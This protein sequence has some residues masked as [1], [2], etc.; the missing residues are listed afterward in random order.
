MKKT[1]IFIQVTMLSVTMSL[2]QNGAISGLVTDTENEPIPGALVR[3]NPSSLGSV[4]DSDGEYII[5]KI[6]AGKYTLEASYLGFEL[7][8][9]EVTVGSEEQIVVN[10][11]MEESA[12]ALQEVEVIGRTQTEYTPDVTFSATRTG[13]TIKEVPQSIAVLNKEILMDQ[14]I[15]RVAE[16]SENV[17]GITQFR[18]DQFT[19]RGF[20]IKQ[21]Y[22]NGNRVVVST[23]FSATSFTSHYER[24]E[25]VKGPAAALFG[26]SSPGGIVNAVTK[27]PLKNRRASASFTFGSFDT[28]R[29]TTDITGP[30]NEEKNLLYRVNVA[31]ENAETFRDF[32][33]NR[34]L[35]IAPSISY[36]PDNKTS[37]NVDLVSTQANDQAGVDRGMPVLQGDLFALP[38]N[39]NTAEP[40]DN[41]QNTN[42]LLTV[43]ANRK[44]TDF[45]SFNAS[46]SRSDFDQ[47]FLETRSSNQFTDDG[48]ELIRAVNDRVTTAS[49]NFLA[50][51]LVGKF[52]TGSFLKHELVLGFDYFENDQ[53]GVTRSA[54][55]EVNGV[56]NLVFSD[57]EVFESL[58]ELLL[59]LS[60]AALAFDLE[61][62]YRG[63]YIQDLIRIGGRLNILAGLRYEDL[64]QAGLEG[65]GVDL[66]DAIDNTVLLPRFGLTYKLT[67]QINLFASY[68]ESFNLQNFPTGVNSLN[69]GEAFDPLES[70]QIEFGTKTSFFNNRLL[71]QVS[72]YAINQSG[73]LIE[74]PSNT[75]G[76]IRLIQLGEEESQGV[77]LDITGS[78]LPNLSIT[79]NYAY[80]DVEITEVEDEISVLELEN[81]NP[82]HTAGFW[83]KYTL[84][85]GLLQNLGIG[86]GLRYVSD[87]QTIDPAANLIDNVI[88]F[89][90]YFTAKGAIYYQYQNMKL[91]FNVNNIFD[92]RYFIGGLN[93]G[94]VFPGAPRNYL[95]TVSYTF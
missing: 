29:A 40:Y 23:D 52:K 32:Q 46:F 13:A 21:D 69:P 26:N 31:W 8:I 6:K 18:P 86:L 94:R 78:I 85:G 39:F 36:F 45:L 34:G 64:D 66:S 95:A 59:N 22:I 1:I 3:L 74:D 16:I 82:Q 44:V 55:G 49:S 47:N 38:I 50:T 75:G 37:I 79:A 84:T 57:R 20:S 51:Y 73:R 15:F 43:S 4:S 61:N 70:D 5:D 11:E 42:T 41:R 62:S 91:S 60:E 90:S 24:V 28:F 12:Y 7:F 83:G 30:L 67:D 9:K 71:A 93:S 92:E 27:K 72:F 53:T 65:D 35:L 56:P 87:S 17:A 80:N 81:N 25:V 19:S 14:Q 58:D 63:Y 77:E 10:I 2:A 33:I 89:P 48:S 68:S 88:S 54:S 76:I